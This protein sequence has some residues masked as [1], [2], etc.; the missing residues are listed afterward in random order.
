MDPSLLSP[1]LFNKWRFSNL[2]SDLSEAGALVDQFESLGPLLQYVVE[3]GW[4]S[5]EIDANRSREV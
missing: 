5:T 3:I 1:V 2:P 4:F